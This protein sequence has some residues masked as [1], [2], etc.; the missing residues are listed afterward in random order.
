MNRLKDIIYDCIL[1]LA[2]LGFR[3]SGSGKKLLIV[4]VDEIGDYMLWHKFLKDIATADAYK[5]YEIHFC[6]NQSWKALF[7][8]FD[9]EWVS[10]SFWMDKTR[11]KKEMRYRYQFLKQIYREG[12]EIVINPT[13]S[14]DKRNDDSIVKAAK[15]KESVGMVSNLESVRSY[16]TGYDKSLYT[17][18]FDH[19]EKPIFEFYRNRLFTEFATSILSSIINTKIDQNRLPSFP[20]VLPEKY[21]IVFPGSRS[22]ARIWPTESFVQVSNYLFE[23]YGWTAVVCGTKGD[24]EY[25]STFFETIQESHTRSYRKN[26]FDRNAFGFYKCRMSF[27]CRYRFRAFGCCCGLHGVWHF[28]WFS[29]QTIRSLSERTEF[30]F[31]CSLSG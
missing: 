23:Q 24:A 14:R 4:R 17:Q 21:F 18:L 29:I 5:N 9:A 16:E 2:A 30:Q 27:V 19:T 8:T 7:N 20:T 15:A 31:L 12:Y 25:T 6:G 22:K 28:Q 1:F 13:F 26:F 10:K 3:K 11:F